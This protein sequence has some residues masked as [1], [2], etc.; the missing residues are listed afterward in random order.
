MSR[1]IVDFDVDVAGLLTPHLTS[2][3]EPI[4]ATQ[5]RLM[6]GGSL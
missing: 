4:A 2:V 5:Y 3:N 1:Q 6:Q